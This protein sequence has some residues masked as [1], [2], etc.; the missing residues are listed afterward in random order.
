LEEGVKPFKITLPI[1]PPSKNTWSGRF[2]ATRHKQGRELEQQVWA[3]VCEAA[4]SLPMTRFRVPVVVSLEFH[5]PDN[6][7]RDIQ[8]LVHP[9]LIDALVNMA[10]IVD[11]SAAWMSLELSSVVDG[12]R[13]TVIR[14]RERDKP[15]AAPRSDTRDTMEDK[16]GINPWGRM[17]GID[18]EANDAD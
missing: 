18:E 3:A 5:L 4:H 15:S 10:I 2:W 11:D 12:T 13:Q 6:R 17:M 1:L 8:N 14:I 7:R 9:G 16:A